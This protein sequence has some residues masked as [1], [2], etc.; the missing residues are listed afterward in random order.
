MQKFI[1]KNIEVQAIQYTGT[2]EALEEFANL[3]L[4]YSYN[5][6]EGTFTIITSKGEA[7]GVIGDYIMMSV[8]GEFDICSQDKFEKLYSAQEDTEDKNE[9]NEAEN[10]DSNK[11]DLYES[12]GYTNPVDWHERWERWNKE[13]LQ[14]YF[15]IIAA[16]IIF[17]FM[18]SILPYFY[19]HIV[20]K[21]IKTTVQFIEKEEIERESKL[22]LE[23]TKL[24]AQAIID[25]AKEDAKKEA[26]ESF[27]NEMERLTNERV[28]K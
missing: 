10:E 15:A 13:R 27:R 7:H 21:T 14:K 5:S 12:H 6:D 25:Q 24:E 11:T 9:S 16:A 8:T 19:D 4:N 20:K 26:D 22:L 1:K 23:K 28:R 17:L 3:G 18:T 2:P